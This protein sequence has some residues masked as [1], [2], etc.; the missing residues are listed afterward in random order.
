MIKKIMAVVLALTMIAAVF[1]AC[2]KKAKQ[3]DIYGYD[4]PV[5]YD[6]NGYAV[7]NEKGE[8]RIYQTDQKG[9]II[10]DDEGNPR[11]SYYSVGG[12]FVHD[13]IIDTMAYAFKMPSGWEVNDTSVFVKRGTDQKCKVSIT[14]A[15]ETSE[16]LEFSEYIDQN[17][18]SNQD[19]VSK[20]VEEGYD[21]TM[22]TEYFSLGKTQSPAYAATYMVKDTDGK[23][24]HYA[25]SIYYLYQTKIY[26]I[27]YI[28]GDGEGY[29]ESFDFLS[30]VK[31]NFVTK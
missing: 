19:N 29:D 10:K 13:N 27:N 6:E 2:G 25:V 15:V 12:S 1:A 5:A 17:K 9:N 31:E 23:L 20:L 16:D 3:E 30:Y 18:I 21:A 4:K 22:E 14:F 7:Y 11:Y 24:I 28:C 26:N 8:V